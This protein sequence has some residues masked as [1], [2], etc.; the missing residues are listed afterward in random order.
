MMGEGALW[1]HPADEL[2]IVSRLVIKCFWKVG[3]LHGKRKDDI[4]TLCHSQTQNANEVSKEENE[5]CETFQ[6]KV[7]IIYYI[8]EFP[9]AQKI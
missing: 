5:Q 9:K 2:W 7:I 3:N 4:A 1:L 8:E 6:R